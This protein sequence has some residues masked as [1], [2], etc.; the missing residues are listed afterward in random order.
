MRE[1][2]CGA[3]RGVGIS[4]VEKM[5]INALLEIGTEEIPARFMVGFLNDLKEKAEKTLSSE[6]IKYSKVITLGAPRRLTLYIENIAPK[7]EDIS[8]ERK[9]PPKEQAFDKDG[10]STNAAK[11][12]AK[13]SGIGVGD[14]VVKPVGKREYIFATV[15][16][17][18]R[19]T[20]QVLKDIFPK[21]VTSMYLPLAMRWGESD[22]KFIRPIHWILALYG[23]KIIKFKLGEIISGK[24]TFGHRYFN[25]AKPIPITSADLQKYKKVLLKNRVI[26]DQDTRKAKVKS[27]VLATSKGVGKALIEEDLLE[28][29]THLVEYPAAAVGKFNPDFLEL[30][31]EVLII[32]MKKNQKYF[33]VLDRQEKLSPAFVVVTDGLDKKSAKYVVD[34]NQRVLSA[35]LSDAKFFFDEDK[36]IPLKVRVEDLKG[37]AFYEKLGNL[38]EKKDRI[39]GISEY[40]AKRLKIS[41]EKRKAIERIAE[42]C[43]ADLTTQMVFEFTE[44]QGIMGREYALASGESKSVAQGIYEHYLPRFTG[45]KLPISIEGVIVSIA[46]RLDSLVGCFSIGLI[47]TGS[48]DPY[49]LR[50]Q[51]HGIVEII[52]KKKLDILLDEAI[53]KSH[54]LFKKGETGYRDYEKIKGSVLDFLAARLK[55]SLEEE[56]IR[57]DVIDAALGSFNDIIDAYEKAKVLMKNVGADWLKGVVTT[58]DRIKRLAVN[59]KR[60][61]IIEGDFVEDGEK[62]M[63]DLYLK[64]NWAVGEAMEKGEWEKAMKELS[65]LTKPV[66]EF[67]E[68]VLVMH[69]DEK[70]KLNRLALLKNMEKMYLGVA[71][72]PKI[73][74]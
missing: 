27:E 36:K 4:I 71:D 14:L 73:V 29:V 40:L 24:S 31:Q 3:E 11:G 44:L 62:V 26:V 59:A 65:K 54:K 22:L 47:P 10:K 6:R 28:E 15:L 55:V 52:L 67:F 37:V 19:A 56:G 2:I 25:G 9:G 30:P 53:E 41:D 61:Q 69:K 51:A 5:K 46:D 8:T 35:R 74:Q 23:N 45:D 42:L 64:T 33:P 32:T 12:F 60:E 57:Y 18:G 72:F 58:A 66:D 49:M 39:K 43:K 34:G 20:E 16:E 50:R 13:S 38:Y 17:K 70:I 63:H 21:V 48:E 68:K 7:Q 1:S